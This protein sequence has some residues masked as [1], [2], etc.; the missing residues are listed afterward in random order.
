M[1]EESFVI[2][3]KVNAIVIIICFDFSLTDWNPSRNV[4]NLS[5]KLSFVHY[6]NHFVCRYWLVY[7]FFGNP[8]NQSKKSAND[9]T[10]NNKKKYKKLKSI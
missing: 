1:F 4:T 7:F 3:L 9:Y 10:R 5:G 2:C 8:L 6:F